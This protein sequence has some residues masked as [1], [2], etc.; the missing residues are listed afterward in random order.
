M[1][2]YILQQMVWFVKPNENTGAD[3]VEAY[4][5]IYYGK[6]IADYAS[7]RSSLSDKEI[8]NIVNSIDDEALKSKVEYALDRIKENSPNAYILIM[9][10]I[11]GQCVI[12]YNYTIKTKV[13][14]TIEEI[15]REYVK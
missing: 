15:E 6:K 13:V 7:K 4:N 9:K 2:Y 11:E 3:F 10:V 12:I 8:D 14:K 1:S 5:K